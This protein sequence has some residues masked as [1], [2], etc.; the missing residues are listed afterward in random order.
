MFGLTTNEQKLLRNLRTPRKIQDF[1]VALPC[2][3]EHGG[4]TCM[5]PRRVLRERR[6]HCIEGAMLAAAALRLHGHPSLLMDFQTVED[7]EDH[8]IAVFRQHGRWGAISKTNHAILRWRD[9]VYRT[10]DELAMSYFHEYQDRGRKTLRAYSKPVDLSRFDRRGWM[11]AEDDLWYI[12]EYLDSVPHVKIL[13]RRRIGLL[14]RLDPIEM[15]AYK[16]V[17]WER[18]KPVIA[19]TPP[20]TKGG[21]RSNLTIASD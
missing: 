20:F 10:P 4:E 16:L 13:D 2:N 12:A 17:E 1:L 5:S 11:T 8:V 18:K 15:K 3:F 7:D 9:P 6:A 19:R 14:R 21:G